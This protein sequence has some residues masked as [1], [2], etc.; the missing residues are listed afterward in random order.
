M[1]FK[2]YKLNILK[3]TMQLYNI[4]WRGCILYSRSVYLLWCIRNGSR[5]FGPE[6]LIQFDV[7]FICIHF[8]SKELKSNSKSKYLILHICEKLYRLCASFTHNLNEIC[9][10]YSFFF[11]LRERKI[12][13]F[14]KIDLLWS[15]LK[16]RGVTLSRTHCCQNPN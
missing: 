3:C 2:G 4:N 15:Y 7:P 8:S 13:N 10:R 5:N 1:K 12:T 9:Y 11:N 6:F 14:R 16:K